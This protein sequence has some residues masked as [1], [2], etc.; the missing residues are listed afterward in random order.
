MPTSRMHNSSRF[1]IQAADY[2]VAWLLVTYATLDTSSC[3]VSKLVTS[4]ATLSLSLPI[5]ECYVD[6]VTRV[7]ERC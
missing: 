7:S 6:T 2:P 1:R 4:S 3:L 5:T